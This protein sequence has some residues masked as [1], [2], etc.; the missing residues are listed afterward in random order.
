MRLLPLAMLIALALIFPSDH[1]F[2]EEREWNRENTHPL[3][4]LE[5]EKYIDQ[6]TIYHQIKKRN[7]G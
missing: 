6:N 2:M 4:D 7:A 5:N 1:V 3:P